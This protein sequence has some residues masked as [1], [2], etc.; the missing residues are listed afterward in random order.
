MEDVTP[1]KHAILRLP[2]EIPWGYAS[3]ANLD[4]INTRVLEPPKFSIFFSIFPQ[5]YQ[6][7]ESELTELNAKL[8]Y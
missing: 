3:E 8:V 4:L 1:R 2:Q 5:K 6:H 7:Y